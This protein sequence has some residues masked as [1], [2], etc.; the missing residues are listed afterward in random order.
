[1]YVIYI[2]SEQHQSLNFKV[3]YDSYMV[4]QTPVRVQDLVS[5]IYLTER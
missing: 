5:D 3:L 4:D 2:W 1:M